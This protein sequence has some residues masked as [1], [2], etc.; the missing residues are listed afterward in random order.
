MGVSTGEPAMVN[1]LALKQALEQGLPPQEASYGLMNQRFHSQVW[2]HDQP[3]DRVCLFFHGFTAGPHQMVPMGQH[4]FRAGYNVVVPLL[5]GHGRAGLW[6]QENLPP[7]PTDP[8][9][10]ITFAQQWLNLAALLGQRVMV[11]GLSGG[12][13]LAAWLALNHANQVDRAVL[14][15]PYFSASMRMID[16][17][18]KRI[19]TYF[20]WDA[21]APKADVSGPV[22]GY[23]GFST[24]ALRAILELASE[25][26]GQ[27]KRVPSAP[28]FTLSSD[29]DRAVKNLD[30][31]A[32]FKTALQ[33][34]PQ[35]WYCCFDRVLEVPH[36]MMTEAEG[37]RHHHLLTVMIQAFLESQ[38]TWP[39]VEELAY[40]LTQGQTLP[41]A[42]AE[43]GWQHKCSPDLPTVI[44]MV[45]KA[46]IVQARQQGNVRSRR[47]DR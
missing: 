39:E 40:R 46:P 38:L 32:F 8:Q 41:A 2:L 27:V 34:Q 30:H 26:M 3:R 9:A 13:T 36:T 5:P 25:V 4:F 29:S 22:F 44:T 10:Y 14:C 16:L 45:D 1:Y 42:V 31:V 24:P 28:T 7:L 18:V 19:D 12:A 37:N 23:G 17:F 21:P 20:E 35:S 43:L 47:R 15:A 6:S 11:I 33:R